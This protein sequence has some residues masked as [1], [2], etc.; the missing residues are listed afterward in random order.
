MDFLC[1]DVAIALNQ[2]LSKS[3]RINQTRLSNVKNI[4]I[5]S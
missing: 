2:P 5:S 3:V 4:E 1:I